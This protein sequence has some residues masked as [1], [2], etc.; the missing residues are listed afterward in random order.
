M[1][2]REERGKKGELWIGCYHNSDRAIKWGW[3]KERAAMLHISVNQLIRHGRI[4]LTTILLKRIVNSAHSSVAKCSF[5]MSTLSYL[6]FNSRSLMSERGSFLSIRSPWRSTFFRFYSITPNNGSWVN[7]G[8]KVA[9][10]QKISHRK[11]FLNTGIVNI[12][13]FKVLILIIAISILLSYLALA[14]AAMSMGFPLV[15]HFSIFSVMYYTFVYVLLYILTKY[16]LYER[17]IELIKK[18]EDFFDFYLKVCYIFVCFC[19]FIYSYNFFK[20]LPEVEESIKKDLVNPLQVVAQ[21]SCFFFYF[22]YKRSDVRERQLILLC[23]VFCV[24]STFYIIKVKHFFL[25]FMISVFSV[26]VYKK[27][28][29]YVPLSVLLFYTLYDSLAKRENGKRA[30]KPSSL[31]LLRIGE[32]LSSPL[33]T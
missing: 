11:G 4:V 3:K 15:F 30:I 27:N 6:G 29:D 33:S 9:A 10:R 28:I 22:Q 23:F 14:G 8:T 12:S 32:V 31:R 2:E 20:T 19:Y 21:L 1:K 25:C 26:Y 13:H 16:S 24:I 17:T 5:G 7:H 18:E